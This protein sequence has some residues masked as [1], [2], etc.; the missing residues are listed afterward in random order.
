[1]SF[2][3]LTGLHRGCSGFWELVAD[4]QQ[5]PYIEGGGETHFSA[6]SSTMLSCKECYGSHQQV[7][8]LSVSRKGVL[9]V[10]CH[11]GKGLYGIYVGNDSTFDLI[12]KNV[13]YLDA[14]S[15]QP[16]QPCSPKAAPLLDAN[17]CSST[18]V[19]GLSGTGYIF[20]LLAGF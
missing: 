13:D 4:G 5:A 10:W 1:M 2:S 3:R 7:W 12:C 19:N 20:T 17:A 6:N 18:R 16:Q 15:G 11:A 8:Y 9:T 14:K